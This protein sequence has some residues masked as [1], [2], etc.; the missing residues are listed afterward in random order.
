MQNFAQKCQISM[1][2]KVMFQLGFGQI[3]WTHSGRLL[4]TYNEKKNLLNLS[5]KKTG[6][7]FLGDQFLLIN[8]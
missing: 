3:V 6:F 2:V 1:V 7:S 8:I 5:T 4:D